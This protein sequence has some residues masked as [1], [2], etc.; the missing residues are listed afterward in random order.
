LL[1]KDARVSL[2]DVERFLWESKMTVSGEN[3]FEMEQQIM[4]CWEM[5]D[6]VKMFYHHVGDDPKFAGLDAKAEDEMMNLLLG[7][8]SL[9]DLKF[10]QLFK[11][12]EL[13]TKDFYQLRATLKGDGDE[14]A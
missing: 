2:V 11:T 5:V 7:I 1:I 14:V 6:D 8:V 10:E 12:F 4:K 13:V 9:Y 3:L